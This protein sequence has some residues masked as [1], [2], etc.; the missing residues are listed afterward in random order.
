M[1]LTA[2]IRDLA[3]SVA[4]KYD[5][6]SVEKIHVL[7]ALNRLIDEKIEGI[8]KSVIEKK[9]FEYPRGAGSS[10]VVSD[11]VEQLIKTISGQDQAI[12]VA[13]EIAKDLLNIEIAISENKIPE[14]VSSNETSESIPVVPLEN[15]LE[16]LNSLIGLQAVKSQLSKLINTHQAN[17]LRMKEGLPAVPVG[18]HCVFTGGPGTGKT[19][20]A[21]LLARM[22]YAIGLL[23][24][25]N[26]YEVD[27]SAL[28]A[29][30]VG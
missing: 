22:Y 24:T 12:S 21:R 11:A 15:S 20:V 26:V 6:S 4:K 18:L 17:S 3:V 7:F 28:V 1:S 13:K 9:L 16:G 27:R 30:Y 14:Q 29:G 25:P 2:Q 5:H 10:P 23:P 19:T 8:D